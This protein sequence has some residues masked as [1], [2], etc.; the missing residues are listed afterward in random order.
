MKRFLL[1]TAFVAAVAL[2]AT[3]CYQS[4]ETDLGDNLVSFTKKVDKTTEYVGVKNGLN[5]VVLVEPIWQKVYYRLGTI[6]V[7]K[8]NN[9]ALYTRTGERLFSDM[10]I[11]EVGEKPSYLF[12]TSQGGKYVYMPNHPLFGPAE[13][14][15]Y[16]PF[17]QLLFF[18]TGAGYGLYNL[19]TAETEIAPKYKQ[20][21]YATDEKGQDAFY[22]SVDGKTFKKLSDGK[23]TAVKLAHLNLMKKE[24]ELNKTP[25]PTE[26][27]SAVKVKILR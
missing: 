1:I 13:H 10:S 12:F 15:I 5:D 9:F 25:W 6:I 24:A 7:A 20:L 17:Y 22:G 4:V 21:V 16:M 3:S 19:D 26:G 8:D 11:R 23:E 27:V 14:F 18:Q 2:M